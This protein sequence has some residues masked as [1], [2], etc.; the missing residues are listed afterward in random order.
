[1]TF[2]NVLEVFADYLREDTD[3]E[4]VLTKRGYTVMCW[5][6]TLEDWSNT[7]FCATP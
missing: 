2:E 7:D 4:I 1:M 3:L 5:E 6:N